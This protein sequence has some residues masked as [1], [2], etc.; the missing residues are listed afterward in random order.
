[1]SYYVRLDYLNEILI[2]EGN[3]IKAMVFLRLMQYMDYGNVPKSVAF[4]PETMARDLQ[5]DHIL[6]MDGT[7][8]DIADCFHDL[9][10]EGYINILYYHD[11]GAMEIET[12]KDCLIRRNKPKKYAP[13]TQKGKKK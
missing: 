9:V 8:Q 1:M 11:N 2:H 4:N 10:N 3:T 5:L 7:D 13:K 12:G 6:D